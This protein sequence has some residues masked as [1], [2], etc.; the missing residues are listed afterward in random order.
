MRCPWLLVLRRLLKVVVAACAQTLV[1]TPG[2]T[3]MATL[4]EVLHAMTL[5]TARIER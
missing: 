4:S 1:T 5:R 2:D 3:T